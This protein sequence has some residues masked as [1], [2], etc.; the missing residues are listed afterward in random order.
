MCH[1]MMP[2]CRDCVASPLRREDES[3]SANSTDSLDA[4]FLAIALKSANSSPTRGKERRISFENDDDAHKPQRSSLS[5]TRRSRSAHRSPLTRRTEHK[6]QRS[7]LSPTARPRTE[8]ARDA[9]LDGAA[10][11][12]AVTDVWAES[13][14]RIDRLARAHKASVTGSV[15]QASSSRAGVEVTSQQQHFFVL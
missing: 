10:D 15:L 6:S 5:P 12:R 1:H 11:K 2:C 3:L 8:N 14:E 7:S 9:V 13:K 4:F